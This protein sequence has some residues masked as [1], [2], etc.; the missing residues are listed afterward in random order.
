M[1]P[2]K[3]MGE[4]EALVSSL[5]EQVPDAEVATDPDIQHRYAVDGI[6]PRLV[7]TPST[8]EDTAQIVALTQQHDLKLMMRGGGSHMN[9]GGLP[10]QIDVLVKTNKLT[11]LLE[12]EAPDL[13]CHVEA[14][15]TLADLQTQ[16]AK[17]GQR[18]ALDPPAAAQ[19]T[20]GGILATNA[21][22][23]K[24]LRYG[25]ARDLVIGLHVIQANGEIARSGG[26]VVKNV[27]GYDLNKLYTGS[28]GTL[29]LIAKAN[30]KLHPIPVAERTLLLTYTN[31]EE[32]MRT[33]IAIMGSQL[34]PSAVEL[35]DAGAANDMTDFFGQNLPGN[36]Y[37]LAVNFE[38]SKTTINRQIDEL[39]LIARKYNAL[40]DNDLEGEAQERFWQAIREH[41]QGTLTC[42]A[43]I[44][45]SHIA[46]YLQHV[47][48]ICHRHDLQASIIAHAANGILYIELRPGDAEPRLTEAIAA[49]RLYAQ[50]ARGSLVVECCPVELKRRI[51]IWGEPGTDFRMMQ[52]LKQQFDPKETF[53]KGRFL[54]GM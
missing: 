35:I 12:H 19:T 16:L 31:A 29:G 54:G 15:I 32:A 34:S 42:K 28:L 25:T 1:S 18:L 49:L 47:E 24:R 23:P 4:I 14:G 27:A 22:G 21:S 8:V 3:T 38:G 7:T 26:R 52:R 6:L 17:Q 11:R 45:V 48:Q 50:E 36:G 13:T 10:E 40:L 2:V 39:R 46:P 5:Q 41:M 51:D 9:L 44:L 33:T 30:F 37:T 20:I 43:A 53:T